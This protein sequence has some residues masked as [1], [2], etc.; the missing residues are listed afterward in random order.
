[1]VFVFF[2]YMFTN[3]AFANNLY[4]VIFQYDT[5]AGSGFSA[6]YVAISPGQITLSDTGFASGNTFVSLKF[7]TSGGTDCKKGFKTKA[8]PTKNVLESTS[9]M[10]FTVSYEGG[11][12]YYVKS[13]VIIRYSDGTMA[14]NYVSFHLY[15]AEN[16]CTTTLDGA[17]RTFRNIPGQQFAFT[18]VTKA[19]CQIPGPGFFDAR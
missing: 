5:E 11:N 15:T 19:I 13:E 10:C 9:T 7:P 4:N 18:R 2:M 6:K 16:G 3:P 8:D 12:V 1:M 17:W 14:T